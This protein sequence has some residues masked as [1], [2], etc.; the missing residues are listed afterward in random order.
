MRSGAVRRQSSATI[1]YVPE[2][3]A[4][5]FVADLFVYLFVELTCAEPKLSY[6]SCDSRWRAMAVSDKS[7]AIPTDTLSIT[8]LAARHARRQQ[9]YVG[10]IIAAFVH[11]SA[12]RRG[13]AADAAMGL[14]SARYYTL[15]AGRVQRRAADAT[16]NS[17]RLRC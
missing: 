17:S 8:Q 6:R 16:V 11:M 10:F 5:T 1:Y 4:L 7:T 13:A 9:Q 14:V 2:R 12:A 15:A 3:S